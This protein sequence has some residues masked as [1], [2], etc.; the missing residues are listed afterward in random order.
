MNNDQVFLSCLK[1]SV[2]GLR[3]MFLELFYFLLFYHS[4]GAIAPKQII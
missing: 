1:L 3:S 2:D 4:D